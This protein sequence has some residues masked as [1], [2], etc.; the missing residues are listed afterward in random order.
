M[1]L[2]D[3]LNHYANARYDQSQRDAP[4]DFE[5]IAREEPPEALSEG[6]AHAFRAEE[7][8]SFGEMVSNLFRNSDPHQRSG[9]LERLREALGG[10]EP[11]D[12]ADPR[13]VEELA[14]KAESR[15]PNIVE[16]VSR[17][18]AQHPALVRNLGSAALTIAL[19]RMAQRRR[20]Q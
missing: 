14:N 7:T 12:D 19:S 16:R 4:R 17:F 18:Y 13:Q 2:R 20:M 1:S 11:L 10:R 3:I 8:P 9:L 6:L 5:E 15:S